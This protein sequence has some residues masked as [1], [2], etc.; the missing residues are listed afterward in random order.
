VEPPNSIQVKFISCLSFKGHE[1]NP[2]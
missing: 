1:C 2:I